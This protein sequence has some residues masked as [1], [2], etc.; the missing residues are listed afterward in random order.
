[1]KIFFLVLLI[2]LFCF[3]PSFGQKDVNSLSDRLFILKKEHKYDEAII[4]LNNLI[5]AS[6]NDP[7]LY[8]KRAE[9]FGFQNKL[10]EAVAD[11]TKAIELEPNDALSYIERAKY[12]NLIKNNKAVL[13]NVKTAVLLAPDKPS[14]LIYGAKELVRGEQHEEII[15]ITD[16]YIAHNELKS[17]SDSWVS[18]DAFKIRSESKFVLKDYI[19]A[20]EDSVKSIELI[21]FTGDEEKDKRARNESGLPQLNILF[22]ITQRYL[23][24]DKRIFDY[25]NRIFDVT[26]G[27]INALIE[28]SRRWEARF[29]TP[30]QLENMSFVGAERF[31]TLMINCAELY[32]EK[33]QPEKGIELF[34][35]IIKL[36]PEWIGYS[37]RARFYKKL[38]KYQE[39]INDLTYINSN[40]DKPIS[41]VLMERGDLYVLTKEFDKAIADYE[42]ARAIYKNIEAEADKKISA[43]MKMLENSN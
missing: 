5:E 12:F 27:K 34:D 22:P 31:R 42:L 11:V 21:H 9:F 28:Q 13:E 15:K 18:Y 24:N 36:K 17:K 37:S 26:E 20:L 39:A 30:W 32:A 23:K 19:G 43:V 4:V 7:K 3:I 2:L 1:M 40:R 29:R 6:P 16:F 38:G 41:T 10:D 8:I 35:R 25:Y 33:G 14:I